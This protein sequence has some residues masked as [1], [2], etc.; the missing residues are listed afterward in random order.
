MEKSKTEKDRASYYSAKHNASRAVYV[1]KSD[2]QRLFGEMVDKDG[3]NKALEG[4]IGVEGPQG[5]HE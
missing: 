1:A 2:E 4:G 3:E 5:E